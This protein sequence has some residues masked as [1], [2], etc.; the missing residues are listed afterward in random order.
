VHHFEPKHKGSPAPKKF[1]TAPSSGKDMLTAFYDTNGAVH[2]E[3]MPTGATINS[4]RC[5][6]TLQTFRTSS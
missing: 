3:F 4:E 6:G 5:A 2:S 1:K